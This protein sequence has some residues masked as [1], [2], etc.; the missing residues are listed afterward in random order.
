MRWKFYKGSKVQADLSGSGD[1][2]I[3]H[4]P[5]EFNA[6]YRPTGEHHHVGTYG[7]LAEAKKGC[8]SYENRRLLPSVAQVERTTYYRDMANELQK[9]GELNVS[10]PAMGIRKGCSNCF[11]KE[12]NHNGPKV[13]PYELAYAVVAHG[14]QQFSPV[15]LDT[16]ALV[17]WLERLGVQRVHPKYSGVVMN[18]CTHSFLKPS[19]MYI[20]AEGSQTIIG[21]ATYEVC[22]ECCH[23]QGTVKTGSMFYPA[24][25]RFEAPEGRD[26]GVHARRALMQAPGYPPAGS[27]GW[28]S[29]IEE[30]KKLRVT[31]HAVDQKY[32]GSASFHPTSAPPAVY[33]L[34]H[35][36]AIT[37]APW[38]AYH[39]DGQPR[40]L[41]AKSKAELVQAIR[42]IDPNAIVKLS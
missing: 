39:P 1:Y 20:R 24:T 17:A 14:R 33:V 36:P 22:R 40:F 27:P 12:Y 42:K 28:P 26:I 34:R 8:E 9:Y 19:K 7:T 2:T 4:R 6:S 35:E 3:S 37:S 32:G 25:A 13:A 38:R 23:V 16:D 21:E 15:I 18:T 29:R 30:P 5:G 41:G 11:I 31:R 10:I